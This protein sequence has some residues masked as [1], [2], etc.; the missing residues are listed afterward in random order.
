[1]MKRV[2]VYRREYVTKSAQRLGL[3]IM[4]SFILCT[5]HSDNYGCDGIQAVEYERNV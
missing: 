5:V 2:T 4:R 1:M 3:T